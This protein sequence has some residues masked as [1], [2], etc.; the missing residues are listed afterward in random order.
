VQSD[1]NPLPPNTVADREDAERLLYCGMVRFPMG[2]GREL[3]YSSLGDG[4]C[5]FVSTLIARYLTGR[6]RLGTLEE[7]AAGCSEYADRHSGRQASAIRRLLG[8]FK[9]SWG[10][11]IS[12]IAWPSADHEA[13]RQELHVLVKAG[14]LIP[15]GTLWNTWNARHRDEGVASITTVAVPTRNRPNQLGCSLQSYISKLSAYD[16][17]P[18]YVVC[19]D[20]DVRQEPSKTRAIAQQLAVRN[21]VRVLYVGREE[22]RNFIERLVKTGFERET[23]EFALLGIEGCDVQTGANRNCIML[24]TAGRMIYSVDDDTQYRCW[25]RRDSINAISLSA[26]FDPTE[27]WFLCDEN[28]PPAELEE[29]DTDILLEHERLLG[30]NLGQVLGGCGKEVIEADHVCGHLV[31][32]LVSAQGRVAATFNGL[33]GDSGMYSS[34]GLLLHQTGGTQ[35][36]LRA[37]ETIY[38]NAITNKSVVRMVRNT[39][40]SHGPPWMGTMAGLDNRRLLPPYMPVGRNQ[41]GTFGLTIHQCF[42]HSYFGHIPIAL[43]H[44]PGERRIYSC[45]QVAGLS[46]IR[47]SDIIQTTLETIEPGAGEEADG[48]RAA[49]RHLQDLGSAQP[50]EFE[51]IVR[52]SLWKRASRLAICCEQMLAASQ[53]APSYWVEDVKHQLVALHEAVTHRDYIVPSDTPCKTTG[54]GTKVTPSQRA[55]YLFGKLLSAWPDIVAKSRDYNEQGCGMAAYSRY[56]EV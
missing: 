20:S 9:P 55:L 25:Q 23:V 37:S 3:A 27:F 11:R 21:G 15:E 13:I 43:L 46:H 42:P 48:L 32:S 49:G 5:G 2:N 35:Q 45:N 38:R 24:A 50:G 6:V 56:I 1:E 33:F 47:L 17:Y 52:K 30:S 31:R 39:T 28:S 14:L 12:N 18:D 51:T 41:D 19:D 54:T 10:K 34:A 29:R 40:V 16:R 44:D 4:K 22:K 53:G 7:Y 8:A 36:R 26:G